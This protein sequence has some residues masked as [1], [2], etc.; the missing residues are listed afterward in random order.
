MARQLV[1]DL[2]LDFNQ[3]KNPV[4]HKSAGPPARYDSVVAELNPAAWW[5]LSDS[6]STAVDS[7]GYGHN[8][9]YVGGVT[10]DEAGPI[11][12]DTAAKFDGTSG[13]V[14]VSSW[15]ETISGQFSVVAW[16]SNPGTAMVDLFSSRSPNDCGVS[17]RTNAGNSVNL[18]VGTGSAWIETGFSVSAASINN[19][20]YHLYVATVTETGATLYVDNNAPGS[21]TWSTA[22]PVLVDPNHAPRISGYGSGTG[23]ELFPG[24]IAQV[25]LFDYALSAAQVASLWSASSLSPA[26]GQAYY[27]TDTHQPYVH[28]GKEWAADVD[29]TLYWMQVNP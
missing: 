25:A 23:A 3:I 21:T 2:D 24:S 29:E 1:T 10:L 20:N 6:S 17:L 13:Y 7:S 28:N 27:D 26:E 22:T 14:G 12:G 8:A 4:L 5:K 15:S 9:V 16:G 18:I 19:G 11:S